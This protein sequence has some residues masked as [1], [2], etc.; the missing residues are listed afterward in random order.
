MILIGLVIALALTRTKKVTPIDKRLAVV[1]PIDQSGTIQRGKILGNVERGE[2]DL[3]LS[4]PDWIDDEGHQYSTEVPIEKKVP[5]PLVDG[6]KN[7][8][9]MWIIKDEGELEAVSA[10]EIFG[11]SPTRYDPLPADPKKLGRWIL[12][13]GSH[14]SVSDII[15][16]KSFWAIIIPT[17]IMMLLLGDLAGNMWPI[18]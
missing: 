1:V 17:A 9:E 14:G 10:S 16:N 5:L 6:D 2:R 13:W 8:I 15:K 11:K 7:S 18:K 12:P 3:W 4:D